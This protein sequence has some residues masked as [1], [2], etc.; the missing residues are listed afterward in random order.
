MKVPSLSRIL[1]VLTCTGM[2]P[3]QVTGTGSSNSLEEQPL[4]QEIAR[5]AMPFLPN[6]TAPWGGP[7]E[8]SL[9]V[10]LCDVDGDGDL[11]LFHNSSGVTQP[12]LLLNDGRGRFT[13]VTATNL[14]P[15][16]PY[17]RST[18]NMC[19]GDI[20]WDG[21]PDIVAGA[22]YGIMPP[23][24]TYSIV[25]INDGTGH[26]SDQSATRV[27][28]ALQMLNIYNPSTA[29]ADFDGDG[30]LDIVYSGQNA[31]STANVSGALLRNDGRGYFTWDPSCFPI[32]NG[33]RTSGEGHLYSVDLDRDGDIDLIGSSLFGGIAYW[34]NDGTGHFTDVSMT[35]IHPPPTMFPAANALP[36][37]VDGDGDLDIAVT[38]YYAHVP[39]RL[40]LN[41]GTGQLYDATPTNMPNDTDGGVTL[42]WGDFDG[43]GDL[44]LLNFV[45]T[46]ASI[47]KHG[48]EQVLLNDGTGHFTTNWSRDVFALHTN[49]I[50]WDYAAADLD[51]DG[52]IDVIIPDG[53]AGGAGRGA[54]C[55]TRYYL[56]TTRQV[57]AEQPATR[58]R[59]WRVT[60]YGPTHGAALLGY[61]LGATHQPTPFGTLGLD[62]SLLL[63]WPSVLVFG[64]DRHQVAEI[65]IPNLPILAGRPLY[66][67]ALVMA[68]LGAAHFT[69]LWVEDAIR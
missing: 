3:A 47:G 23:N 31:Y 39:V 64:D 56:N 44:D 29:L 35:S 7:C 66:A 26:F 63:V 54:V 69:N 50:V 5:M 20:D 14:P 28:P 55:R 15:L 25:Y 22:F 10:L 9:G 27:P 17:R 18:Y 58:N 38:Q 34:Q 61:A 2:L 46:I 12:R 13:E 21:D 19:A 49:G 6:T 43:D 41:D 24:W 67:Q 52:D 16:T 33:H 62:P 60:V 4:M 8:A 45:Q 57:F 11:D 53:G 37:D 65:P 36:A 32:D 68:P 51:D 42:R 59:P 40:Y 1:F 30:D 48:E